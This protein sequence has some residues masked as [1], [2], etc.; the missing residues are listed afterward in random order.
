[1]DVNPMM[2]V[3]LNHDASVRILRSE[4]ALYEGHFILKTGKH[5]E[6]FFQ[7]SNILSRPLATYKLISILVDLIKECVEQG[8]IDIPNVVASP[9]TGGIIPGYEVAKHLNIDFLFLEKKEQSFRFCRGFHLPEKSK[10]LLVDDVIY[11]GKS[12]GRCMQ[13]LRKQCC[14]VAAAAFLFD[15]SGG[16]VN[17]GIPMM[18]A[19]SFFFKDYAPEDLPDDLADTPAIVPGERGLVALPSIG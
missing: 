4:N 11:S 7:K 17:I 6:Y 5:T 1:M 18:A 8:D 10:I 13:A 14:E 15:R 19:T 9:A 2:R 12:L 3:G 16:T